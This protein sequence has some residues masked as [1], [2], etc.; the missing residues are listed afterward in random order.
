MIVPAKRKLIVPPWRRLIT[1]LRT[2]ARDERGG[3]VI[4]PYAFGGF[5]VEAAYFDGTNDYLTRGAAWT[6][7]ADSS[8]GLLSMWIKF[9]GA[10]GGRQEILS[11]DAQNSKFFR[12]TS[13]AFTAD[14]TTSQGGNQFRGTTA[15][16][17]AS[18]WN[19]ILC[20]W[21]YTGTPVRQVYINDTD[22]YAL[23]DGG[24]VG[25][26]ATVDWTA[27]DHTA[28]ATTAAS[29]KLNGDVADFYLNIAE[30]LDISVSGNRLRFRTAGGKPKDI[31]ADGSTPTGN[32][33]IAFF[34]LRAGESASEFATNRGYGGGMTV[35]GS[36]T[37]SAT[38]PSD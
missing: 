21:D 15:L 24:V 22:V 36:L 34:R 28:F 1:P 25:A 6:S 18:G 10:D 33:P 9:N 3:M 38:S 20:A 17:A 23:L 4:N 12:Q 35:T 7:S 5:R 14:L 8:V 27:T 2:F 37:V 16:T 31:G 29:N 32:D 30:T 19:H 26:G 11:W 13:N